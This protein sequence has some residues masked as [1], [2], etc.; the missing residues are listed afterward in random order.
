[1]G[2]RSNKPNPPAPLLSLSLSLVLLPPSVSTIPLDGW[3]LNPSPSNVVVPSNVSTDVLPWLPLL[4]PSSTK[5]TSSSMDTFPSLKTSSSLMSPTVSPESPPSP[6][7]VL[8]K[9]L[10]S[11]PLLSWHGCLPPSTTET[12]VLVTS[13]LTLLTPKR[14]PTSSMLN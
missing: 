8:P 14:R 6:P 5:T 2:P 9:S 11:S 3:R 13:E 12:T 7:P 10:P 4:V 1:M